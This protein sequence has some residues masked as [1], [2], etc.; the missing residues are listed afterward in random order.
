[1]QAS[2]ASGCA[3]GLPHRILGTQK[4]METIQYGFACLMRTFSKAT[5]ARSAVVAGQTE[6][7]MACQAHAAPLLYV[8]P[9]PTAARRAAA[10]ASS[11]REM[12]IGARTSSDRFRGVLR[13]EKK[14]EGY[15]STPTGLKRLRTQITAFHVNANGKGTP[16]GVPQPIHK[17][18][19]IL[20]EEEFDASSFGGGA[21]N[22]T[23]VHE[24][25]LIGISKLSRWFSLGRFARSDTLA[26]SQPVRS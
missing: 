1:M 14:P 9:H 16:S 3:L 8:H 20:V 7:R 19:L 4:S 5:E 2:Y 17:R 12:H 25:P 18:K 6:G 21:E 10:L 13:H 22:R 24:S 23:P 15:T 26:A 11:E